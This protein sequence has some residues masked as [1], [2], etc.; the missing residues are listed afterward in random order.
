MSTQKAWTLV[1]CALV[2]AGAVFTLTSRAVARWCAECLVHP[3]DDLEWLRREFQ[4]GSE[5]MARIRELHAGYLPRCQAFCTQIA[6][7]K[8]ALA[9]ELSTQGTL[10]P[11]AEALV[12][13]IAELR[14]ECQTQMLRHFTE[15]SQAMPPDQGRRYL[16]EMQRLTLGFHEQTE[17][18]MAPSPHSGHGQP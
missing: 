2:T 13:E 1:L 15:V 18:A 5:E 10:T 11:R 4:L 16:A 6:T 14:A 17:R 12:R 7:K 8:S 9:A 3:Q